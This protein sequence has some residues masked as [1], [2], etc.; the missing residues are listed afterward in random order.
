MSYIQPTDLLNFN[1][2]SNAP[3]L[4]ESL[5]KRESE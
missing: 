2:M 4:K 3:A 1:G 5:P